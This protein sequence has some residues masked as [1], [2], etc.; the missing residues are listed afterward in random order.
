MMAALLLVVADPVPLTIYRRQG[1]TVAQV[2]ADLR[3]CRLVT[4]G[5]AA[6]GER[7]DGAALLDNGAPGN[8][9][10]E[11]IAGCMATYGWHGHALSERERRDLSRLAPAARRKALARL[12]GRP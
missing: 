12:V 6:G 10:G 5:P 9:P 8:P 4:T 7:P 2:E 1:A 3:R 11:T